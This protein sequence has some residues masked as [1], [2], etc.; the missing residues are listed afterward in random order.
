MNKYT[1]HR[2]TNRCICS[3]PTSLRLPADKSGPPFGT[4]QR[5]QQ[6][7]VAVSTP[8]TA[9]FNSSFEAKSIFAAAPPPHHTQQAPSLKTPHNTLKKSN[10]A[11]RTPTPCHISEHHLPASRPAH[12]YSLCPTIQTTC[13]K[14][15][16]RTK[17]A[18]P[19]YG[20]QLVASLSRILL[21]FFSCCSHHV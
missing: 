16:Q 5:T 13:A 9:T 2:T 6:P 21:C 15:L 7:Q 18:G 20:A 10:H 4:L 1:Q 3:L 14:L 8:L 17:Q 11:A 12:T 19:L